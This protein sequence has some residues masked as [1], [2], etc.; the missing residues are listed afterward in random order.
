MVWPTILSILSTNHITLPTTNH[1]ADQSITTFVWISNLHLTLTMN[2]I[3]VVFAEAWNIQGPVSQKSR[4]F[5]GLLRVPQSPLYL[6]NAEVL[7]HH[8]SQSSSFFLHQKHVKRSAFQNKQIAGWQLAFR[9]RKVLWTFE[10]Q[11]PVSKENVSC[12]W[13]SES[14]EFDVQHLDKGQIFP[15]KR[16]EADDST[17]CRSSAKAKG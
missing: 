10:K 12:R 5:S 9:A 17:V 6:R 16:Y 7:S 2:S 13:G 15:V 3:E 4:N 1:N 8:S 11:S 14:R